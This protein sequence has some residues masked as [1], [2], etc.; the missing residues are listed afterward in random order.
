M[1]SL[2]AGASRVTVD[3]ELVWSPRASGLEK[4][5]VDDSDAASSVIP[6]RPRGTQTVH[7]AHGGKP[8]AP[9]LEKFTITSC[10]ASRDIMICGIP[11]AVSITGDEP[12]LKL[13]ATPIRSPS[14]SKVFMVACVAVSVARACPSAAVTGTLCQAAPSSSRSLRTAYRSDL[15]PSR[16][17]RRDSASAAPAPVGARCRAQC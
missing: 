9:K 11:I 5:Q 2:R 15:S 10:D 6:E 13:A 7:T 1:W 17:L 16:G 4:L 3:L 12:K 8:A 14:H